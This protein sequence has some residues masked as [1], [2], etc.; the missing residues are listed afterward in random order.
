MLAR[1][2]GDEDTDLSSPDSATMTAT[3]NPPMTSAKISKMSPLTLRVALPTSADN[4]GE[5]WRISCRSDGVLGPFGC[6]RPFILSLM[7]LVEVAIAG[8]LVGVVGT[9]GDGAVIDVRVD[10]AT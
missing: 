7:G 6:H 3:I 4:A 5:R 8:A 9:N 2:T 10:T 1:R